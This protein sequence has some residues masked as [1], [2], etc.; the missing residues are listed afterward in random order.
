MEISEVA[1]GIYAVDTEIGGE[2]GIVFSYVVERKDVAVIETGANSTA[3]KVLDAL[4]EIGLKAEDVRYIAVTHVHLD[5]SGAAGTLARFCEN[6]KII[7]HP[8]GV[9]HLVNPEKLWRASKSVLSEIAEIYGKPTPVDEN[10]ILTAEDLSEFPLGDAKIKVVHTPGHAP[11][12][13]SYLIDGMLFP[14]DSAGVFKDG[15]I[16]PTTPPVFDFEKALESIGKMKNQKVELIA[17]THFGVGEREM[18]DRIERKLMEWKEVA[19]ECEDVE[20]MHNKLLEN[21]EDYR[22]FWNWLKKSK[23]AESYFHLALRGFMEA[24]KK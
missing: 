22:Y 11:H 18:L 2:R 13:Q 5:H 23:F 7:V 16:I 8:R 19:L 4:N 14:G 3:N 15:K 10:R 6:A 1:E 12:H 17:Y 24:V 20:E 9:K 21:D